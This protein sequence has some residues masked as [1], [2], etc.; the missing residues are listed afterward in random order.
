[1][2]ETTPHEPIQLTLT[3]EELELVRNALLNLES[4]MG[5]EEAD[6]LEQIQR[7]LAKLGR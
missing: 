7:L 5:H 1:M 6:T 2:D 3:A 4:I